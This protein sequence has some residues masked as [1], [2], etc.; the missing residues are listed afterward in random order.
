MLESV[1]TLRQVRPGLR[2]MDSGSTCCPTPRRV[3]SANLLDVDAAKAREGA[4]SVN[5]QSRVADPATT[6]STA[7]IACCSVRWA[8]R[9]DFQIA[10]QVSSR[11]A[12]GQTRWPLRLASITGNAGTARSS[13]R[14]ALVLLTADRQDR[15]GQSCSSR[16]RQCQS[17]RFPFS[18][19]LYSAAI[20]G[21]RLN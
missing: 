11:R 17:I 10:N 8:A 19:F 14:Y 9:R 4:A 5:R 7:P 20:A 6:W 18:L 1:L 15:P 16:S 3:F 13:G 21:R 12:A 2:W